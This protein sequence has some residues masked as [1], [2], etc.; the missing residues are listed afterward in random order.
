MVVLFLCWAG[1]G[2]VPPRCSCKKL[3][4]FLCFAP[5]PPPP[6][7][8]RRFS[9]VA[10]TPTMPDHQKPKSGPSRGEGGRGL[11]AGFGSRDRVSSGRSAESGPEAVLGNSGNE[12]RRS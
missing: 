4:R 3:I 1:G 8:P 9:A 10:K 11:P 12:M 2:G 7:P 6:P 5:A